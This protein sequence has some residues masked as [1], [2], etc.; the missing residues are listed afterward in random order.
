[1]S[2]TL[3]EPEPHSSVTPKFVTKEIAC[4]NVCCSVEY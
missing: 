4:D 3:W 2:A 1:L